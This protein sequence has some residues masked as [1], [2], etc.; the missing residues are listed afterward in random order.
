[1]LNDFEQQMA[2]NLQRLRSME[3]QFEDAKASQSVVWS[4]LAPSFLC[5]T[6]P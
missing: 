1:M 4:R 5:L 2:A 6:E 3:A